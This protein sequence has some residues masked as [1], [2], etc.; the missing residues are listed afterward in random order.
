MCKIVHVFVCACC[1]CRTGFFGLQCE[2]REP[3]VTSH[4]YACTADEKQNTV[5]LNNGTCFAMFITNWT[6]SCTYVSSLWLLSCESI[7]FSYDCHGPKCRS[8]RQ[9]WLHLRCRRLGRTVILG[10][11][12]LNFVSNKCFKTSIQG[13]KYSCSDNDNH[14]RQN[15][16][17]K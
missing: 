1:S 5:C 17:R 3:D 12:L 10:I 16:Q 13:V 14:Q 4:K 11:I 8:A 6:T 2:N 15:Y 7:M 9:L